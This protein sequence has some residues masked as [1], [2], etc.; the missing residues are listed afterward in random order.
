MLCL[1]TLT[2]NV[3]RCTYILDIA[4]LFGQIGPRTTLLSKYQS[5]MIVFCDWLH[6]ITVIRVYDSFFRK[7]ISIVHCL[8]LLSL[9][10]HKARSYRLVATRL[11]W[12]NSA[13]ISKNV[14]NFFNTLKS[15]LLDYYLLTIFKLTIMCTNTCANPSQLLTATWDKTQMIIWHRWK[16]VPF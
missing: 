16:D 15:L 7:M 12:I 5:K 9:T 3:A 8:L 4:A 13:G 6:K 1:A 14:E 2:F 10:N 11:F